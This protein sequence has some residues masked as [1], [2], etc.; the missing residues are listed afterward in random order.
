R[1]ALRV[2]V[3]AVVVHRH[4]VAARDGPGDHHRRGHVDPHRRDRVADPD[5]ITVE[6]RSGG[7]GVLRGRNWGSET[8]LSKCAMKAC[9]GMPMVTSSGSTS[10]RFDT[11]R[12]PSSTSISAT[13]Y[14][15]SNHGQGG[16][17]GRTKLY[18]SPPPADSIV[19]HS[20]E[21]QRGHI[22]H[23]PWRRAPHP[24]HP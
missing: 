13:I 10:H 14:V 5:R 11:I 8:P 1:R 20:R 9:T 19:S 15:P 17:R 3:V 18:T 16:C 21:L 2:G 6:R 24:P 4:E 23:A 7:H 22:R 12:V